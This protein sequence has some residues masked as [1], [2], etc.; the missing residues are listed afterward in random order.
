MF[1]KRQEVVLFVA[2]CNLFLQLC[3]FFLLLLRMQSFSV[4]FYKK[5]TEQYFEAVDSILIC[6]LLSECY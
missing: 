2:S 5:A 1:Q 4:T 6:D 3:F